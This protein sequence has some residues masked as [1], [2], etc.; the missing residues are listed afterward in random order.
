[1][2]DADIQSVQHY[3][4]DRGLTCEMIGKKS[5]YRIDKCLFYRQR[6]YNIFLFDS[7]LFCFFTSLDTSFHWT[8]LHH[9]LLQISSLVQKFAATSVHFLTQQINEFLK[10]MAFLLADVGCIF[11]GQVHGRSAMIIL[12]RWVG[13]QVQECFTNAQNA[14]GGGLTNF[15][16]KF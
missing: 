12:C 9:S 13:S 8:F 2:N 14:L 5:F 11:Y 15:Y 10:I 7:S 3:A 6:Q 4:A 1:M 16:L